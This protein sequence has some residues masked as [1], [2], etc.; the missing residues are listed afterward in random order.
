[1]PCGKNIL[2]IIINFMQVF[3]CLNPLKLCLSHRG[4]LNVLNKI[5]VD[6]DSEVQHWSN[7]LTM[8]ARELFTLALIWLEFYDTVREADGDRILLS[9]KIMLPIFTNHTNYL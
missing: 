3:S 5:C 6:Y 4:T 2:L 1:M 8:Y 9:W 7:C